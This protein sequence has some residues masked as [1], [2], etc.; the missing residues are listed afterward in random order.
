MKAVPSLVKHANLFG[1][2]ANSIQYNSLK[3]HLLFNFRN[4]M[5]LINLN[6]LY[7]HTISLKNVTIFCQ[8][9]LA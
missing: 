1:R 6:Y 2:T 9:A 7:F 4:E 8:K 5:L 3:P